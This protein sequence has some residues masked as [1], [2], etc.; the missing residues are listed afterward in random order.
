MDQQQQLTDRQVWLKWR[1]GGIG[2]SDAASV[3]NKSPHSTALELFQDKF[4]E[5]ESVEENSFIMEMGNRY[6]PIARKL[7]AAEYNIRNLTDE[8]FEPKN[9]VSADWDVLRA[10]LDGSSQSGEDTIE[11]KFQGE[12]AHKRT[13]DE[14]LPVRGGRV[15]EHYWIQI[16]HQLLV[17]GA[18]KCF[19]VSYNPKHP[20]NLTF[21][22]VTP[23]AEFQLEHI[24]ACKTFWENGLNGIAPEPSDKD[25][26]TLTKKGAKAKAKRLVFLKEKIAELTEEAD[27]VKAILVGMLSHPKMRCA[28]L[29]FNQITKKGS[30]DYAKIPEVKALAAEKLE[31]YRKKGTTY[32]DVRLEGD[33]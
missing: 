11:I 31:E 10:S 23:D 15:P 26:V 22:E 27:E 20:T 28:G 12:D 21:V 14:S 6:E 32:Y 30:I 17:S 24:L 4:G 1:R 2:S 5:E 16:Q 33:E 9:I 19:L 18:K 8:T 29:R 7:F 25:F 3:H 13:M